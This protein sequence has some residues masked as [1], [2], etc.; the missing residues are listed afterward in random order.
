[1]TRLRLLAVLCCLLTAAA[2]S[3]AHEHAGRRLVLAAGAGAAVPRLTLG[4]LR[5]AYLGVPVEKDGIRIVPLRNLSDPL[6][7][8]IFLQ[9]VLFMS[10][11]SYERRLLSRTL[12]SG[13]QRP[14]E[15][16]DLSRLRVALFTTP[17]AVTYMWAETVRATPGLREVQTLW[18]GATE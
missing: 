5:Q 15:Y 14:P 2:P 3:S 18:D 16:T 17:G 8:E 1:M 12:Q 9:K 10:A 7:Y 6:L 13:M 11:R 4:E